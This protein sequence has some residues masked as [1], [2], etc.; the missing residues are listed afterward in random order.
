MLLLDVK[1]W[2]YNGY[3]LLQ[4]YPKI[5]SDILYP[6]NPYTAVNKDGSI[7]LFK[8]GAVYKLN[9]DLLQIEGFPERVERVFP[10]TINWIEAAITY[11]SQ[12]L[13]FKNQE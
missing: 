1:V 11:N 8:G 10:G 5:V 9:T 12:I 6:F 4:G 7:Y 2:A 3:Y 13:F